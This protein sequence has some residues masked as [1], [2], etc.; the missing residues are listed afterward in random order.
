MDPSNDQLWPNIFLCLYSS[1]GNLKKIFIYFC[2]YQPNPTL[3]L[4]QW[5]V[6][7]SMRCGSGSPKE[8]AGFCDGCDSKSSHWTYPD[9]CEAQTGCI[10]LFFQSC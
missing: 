6:S 5:F 8:E 1:E 7:Q 9:A 4:C 10:N 2:Y 3:P